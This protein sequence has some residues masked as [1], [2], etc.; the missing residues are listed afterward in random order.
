MNRTSDI[1]HKMPS[2]RRIRLLDTVRGVMVIYMIYY[3]TLFDLG[4]IFGKGWARDQFDAQPFSQMIIGCT[5]VFIAGLTIRFSRNAALHGAKLLLIAYAMSLITG[6]I[7]YGQGIYFGVLHLLAVCMLI[8]AVIG[9]VLDRIHWLPGALVCLALYV[10]TYWVPYGFFGI[11]GLLKLPVPPELT[12][13]SRLYYFGFVN[14]S[15]SSAD[16]YPLLP[17]MF[18]FLCGC[19]IGRFLEREDLPEFLFRDYCPALTFIGRHSL[20]IYLIHQPVLY[21]ICS[22]LTGIF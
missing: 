13:G 22:I 7:M 18:L 17:W 10:C 6:W 4:F 12:V 1:T 20:A 11:K 8:Y 15:F 9:K 3:H 21:A 5:F 16:F 14:A 19:F 2:T